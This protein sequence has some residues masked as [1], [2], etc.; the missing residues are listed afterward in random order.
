MPSV[1]GMTFLPRDRTRESQNVRLTLIGPRCELNVFPVHTLGA[2][3]TVP[4]L[5][6]GVI[7]C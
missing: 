6:L 1:P 7:L 3:R 5:K 4:R 2:F